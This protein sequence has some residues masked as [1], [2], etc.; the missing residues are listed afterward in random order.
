MPTAPKLSPRIVGC[1]LQVSSK[2]MAFCGQSLFK[3]FFDT[4]LLFR[5]LYPMMLFVDVASN[6]A[7]SSLRGFVQ[8]AIHYQIF[9]ESAGM[10]CYLW[11]SSGCRSNA[12]TRIR[13]AAH[14]GLL[15]L[16]NFGRNCLSLY[17]FHDGPQ[18][19]FRC[20]RHW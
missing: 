12:A 4:F 7:F 2:R 5:S 14:V 3:Y 1:I 13:A 9:S 18:C 8:R 20:C 11:M 15:L 10:L 17:R 19:K 6:Q 16:T